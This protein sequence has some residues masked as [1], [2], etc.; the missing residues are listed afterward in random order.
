M[1]EEYETIAQQVENGNYEVS[2]RLMNDLGTDMIPLLLTYFDEEL[3][4][5][6]LAIKTAKIYFMMME[7]E[8]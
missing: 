8:K 1:N 5:P 7:K 6:K 3:G 4:N 2:Y